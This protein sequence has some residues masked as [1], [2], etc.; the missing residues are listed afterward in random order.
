MRIRHVVQTIF[1]CKWSLTILHMMDEGINRPG[2][3]VRSVDGL[4]TKVLNHC[5]SKM[6]EFDLIEKHSY[7]E[8]PPRVE[9]S[10]SDFGRRFQKLFDVLDELEEDLCAD[11]PSPEACGD[12]DSDCSP[13]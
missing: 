9:Y 5:L 4:T 1:A 13:S 7:P 8:V 12:A 10:I 2:A 11:E 6:L 3:M